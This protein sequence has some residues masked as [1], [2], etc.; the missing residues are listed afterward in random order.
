MTLENVGARPVRRG[1]RRRRAGRGVPRRAER[2]R[3]TRDT[4]RTS[5]PSSRSTTGAGRA[6]LS[7]SARA[8]GWRS[9]STEV[10]V[11]FKR[12]PHLP[13]PS[14]RSSSSRPTRS[15]C[16]SSPTRAS[17]SAFGAK[18]PAPTLALR[19]VNM[20]FLYGSS[21]LA[22]APEAYETLI[23]DAIR[24]DGTL[25][26]RQD[27]VERSWEIVRP[28]ARA[29]ADR[30]ARSCTAPAHGGPTWRTSSWRGTAAGGGGRDSRRRDLRPG[31]RR[32]DAARRARRR[33][34][35]QRA[36]DHAQPGRPRPRP[37]VDRGGARGTR[38]RRPVAS[39]AGDR[40][41]ARRRRAAGVGGELVLGRGV[42]SP[43]VLG[44]GARPGRCQGAP[45]RGDVAPRARPARVPLVAGSVRTRRPP[46]RGSRRPRVA[47]HRGLRRLQPRG[48]VCGSAPR[49]GGGRPGLGRAPAVARRG[50]GA[51]RRAQPREGARPHPFG[52][53][54]RARERGAAHGRMG[55]IGA[56]GRH[57]PHPRGA[58]APPRA[59]HGARGE[60]GVPGRARRAGSAR[61]RIGARAARLRG[62]ARP[63]GAAG[64]PGGR[65][66]PAHRRSPLRSGARSRR[67]AGAG[68]HR[69][70]AGDAAG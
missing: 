27:G 70:D 5:P 35:R 64:A 48:R 37:G 66:Q 43:G 34:H 4:R 20:D 3:R 53:R 42:G 54:P 28:A 22:E 61:D 46:G 63:A 30:A 51:L 52:R 14:T 31:G 38:A 15:C 8:S 57:R 1:L 25:F 21:F 60:E 26:T 11:Q 6:R 47:G 24:G 13:F 69:G 65:A 12:P 59:R 19:T 40:G 58:P 16:G 62:R 10:A 32:G 36:G 41:D 29:L 55:A 56:R 9:G 17:R 45:E 2:R 49:P 68:R 18:A 67:P 50:G 39:S 44:A 7:T 33:P 23:L